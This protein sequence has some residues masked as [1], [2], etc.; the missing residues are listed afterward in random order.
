MSKPEVRARARASA[1]QADLHYQPSYPP[2]ERGASLLLAWRLDGR[3]VLLIG[4]GAVAA[5]RLGFLLQSGAHVTIVSPGPLEPSIAYRVATEPDHITWHDRSYGSSEGGN[6]SAD[7][8]LPVGDYDMVLTA[9]DDVALSRAVCLAA[10]EARTPVNVADV[11]PE[12]DFYFG[13]QV[14]RGPLQAMVSTSGAGPKIAVIVRDL[15]ADAIPDNVEDAI[16]GV[17]KLRTELR[18]RA[19]GVGGEL[20][21]RRMRW[22]IGTCDAWTLGEMGA[23]K[24]EGVRKRLLDDGWEKNKVLGPEAVGVGSGLS[25][26]ATKALHGAAGLW[27]AGAGGLVTGAAI[28]TLATLYFVRR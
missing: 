25:A 4:G 14:R 26:R 16:D 3:R 27:A 2:I 22:M 11:P 13:A 24:D 5:S 12:C 20:S 9:V 18:E 17:G 8:E 10:R 7:D 19:P 28:A 15:V 23:M 6:V 1:V 21:K